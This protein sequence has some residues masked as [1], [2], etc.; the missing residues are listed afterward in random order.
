MIF[1]GLFQAFCFC[2]LVANYFKVALEFFCAC[3]F[4]VKFCFNLKVCFD[5]GQQ[6]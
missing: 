1:L 4:W 5:E 3:I 6:I 2:Q